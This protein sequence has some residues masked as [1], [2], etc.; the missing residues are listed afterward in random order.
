MMVRYYQESHYGSNYLRDIILGGQDGLVNVLGIVLGVAAAGG[1][2]GI[3]IAASMAATF[4]EAVSM[5][6][7][8]YTSRMAEKDY[9]QKEKEREEREVKELPEREKEEIKNIFRERGLSGKLLDQ[10]SDVVVSNRKVWVDVMMSDEL[11]LAPVETKSVVTSSL[12]VGFAAVVGS[13]IPVGPF[14]FLPTNLA[15]PVCLVFSA[16]SLFVVGVYKAKTMVGSWWKSG[17]QMTIIGLAA[18]LIG[19][20]IGRIFGA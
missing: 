15:I 18:A 8:S 12:L 3:L 9:Y 4:A 17:L 5:A 20:G 14:L 13:L 2:H 11:H 7:V 16:A 6:A 19:F 1:G 10:V